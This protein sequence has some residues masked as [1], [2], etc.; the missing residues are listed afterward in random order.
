VTVNVRAAEPPVRTAAA[1]LVSILSDEGVGQLF[2]NP[3]MHIA[4][5]RD[6]LAEAGL[7]G[8]PH[9]QAVLCVHEHVALSAAHGHHLASG[10]PQAVMVHVESGQLALNEAIANAQRDRVPVT[11]FY[12]AGDEWRPGPSD[13]HRP[14][15]RSS[16][17]L[18]M[19]GGGRRW[20]IDLTKSNEV[21]Q[22]I[23]R[24][25][26]VARTEPAGV[27]HVALSMER[28][29]QTAGGPSRR[30]LPP[31][32]PAAD[33]AALED[34]AGLLA[35]ARWPVIVAGRVGRHADSV[36]HLARL[37]EALGAPVIDIRN[38][39]NL[40][41]DHPLNAG[42]EGKDLYDRADA[43]LLLDVGTPCIP[44][45]GPPPPQ[46]WLLQIDTDCLQAEQPDW[47]LPIEIAVT[48]E[49]QVA[50]PALTTL[51]GDRL[52]A[53]ALRRRVQERRTRIEK[54]LRG[55]RESWRDRAMSTAQVDRADAM[56]A[57]LQRWLPPDTVIVE[58][59]IKGVHS[60]VRQLERL[61]GNL[62]RTNPP[63]PGWALG[64]AL[65]AR[66]ARPTQPVVALCDE[67]AFVAGMPTAAFW[68]A[69]RAGA[70][71]LAVVLDQGRLR[72]PR[73]AREPQL[74]VVSVA[75]ESRAEAVVVEQPG[76]MAEAL[77]QLLATT[78]DGVCAVLDVRI[79]VAAAQDFYAKPSRKR[80]E[81]TSASTRTK[82]QPA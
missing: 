72:S 39:V 31:R 76:Q 23:R 53:P 47:T 70:P 7:Q 52:A 20:A 73:S 14:A 34:M 46:A 33:V 50:L 51:L 62:F 38:Q 58:E 6:A 17:G 2:L 25:F 29:G 42:L 48:A 77:D 64:A 16:S 4:P 22:L 45:V 32:P 37:A 71:F 11:L 28:L 69:H 13:S 3:G 35:S 36:H 24:A 61:P 79:P 9:P 21:S 66:L 59:V 63:R 27:T 18:P 65:G 82:R 26:Q 19:L 74:D 55:I 56:L 67:T 49:T 44:G 68:S 5:L 30:L 41:P 60:T 57:E 80:T 40:P 12:G 75:R 1:E 78:R 15:G 43:V 81:L 54:E 10:G 8:I